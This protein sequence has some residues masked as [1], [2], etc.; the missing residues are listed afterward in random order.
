VIV[1][2]Y[3]VSVEPGQDLQKGPYVAETYPVSVEQQY[4]V[5]EIGR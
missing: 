4:V 3:E 5:V 1:R 2:K